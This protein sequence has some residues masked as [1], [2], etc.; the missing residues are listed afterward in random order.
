MSNDRDIRKDEGDR[1]REDKIRADERAVLKFKDGVKNTLIGAA[2]V[3]VIAIGCWVFLGLP[4]TGPAL[5]D[6]LEQRAHME[7]PD[8]VQRILR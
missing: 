4:T 6:G 1:Y 2:I 5:A 7:L 8:M 3:V